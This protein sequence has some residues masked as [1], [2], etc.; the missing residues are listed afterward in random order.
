MIDVN[1]E[2]FAA[3]QLEPVDPFCDQVKRQPRAFTLWDRHIPTYGDRL[4]RKYPIASERATSVIVIQY[5]A[6]P[7]LKMSS[8][9]DGTDSGE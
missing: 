5:S 2:W 4:T 8:Q 1:R 3:K 7:V 9:I 6:F